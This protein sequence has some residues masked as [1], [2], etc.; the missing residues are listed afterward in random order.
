MALSEIENQ[1]GAGHVVLRHAPGRTV[2]FVAV[3]FTWAFFFAIQVVL[4]PAGILWLDA[5]GGLLAAALVYVG[6]VVIIQAVRG[7]PLLEASAD[8]VTINSP[9]GPMFVRWRDAAEFSAGNFRWL[10][11]R[12][13]GGTRPVASTWTRVAN[14]SL[15][16]RRTIAV[17]AF[18]TVAR[19][20][21]IAE[22]LS[23]LHAR[24]GGA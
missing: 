6:F 10:R 3:V 19:P 12:L 23:T 13:R 7:I 20:T 2:A 24:Y 22:G 16:A 1:L 4:H 15:W 17:P 21:E 11:I 18:T 14:A 9:W 5:F 8:G